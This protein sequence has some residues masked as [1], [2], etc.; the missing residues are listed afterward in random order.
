MNI[1]LSI[2]KELDKHNISILALSER[3]GIHR[4]ALSK[5]INNS[6]KKSNPTIETLEKIADAIGCNVGDFFVENIT[7]PEN[8]LNGKEI[9]I[10]GITYTLVKK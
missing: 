6:D 9:T 4:V 7:Q 1:T 8:T 10:D 2:K 5:I 3:T